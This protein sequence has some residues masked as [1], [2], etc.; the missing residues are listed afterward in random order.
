M[1][2]STFTNVYIHICIF[3]YPCMYSFSVPSHAHVLQCVLQCLL[4]SAF[5][6]THIYM[7]VYVN[8]SLNHALG[9]GTCIQRSLSRTSMYMSHAHLCRCL[10]HIYMLPSH[11]HLHATHAALSRT[12]TCFP[13]THIYM[14][15]SHA[16][17]H[18]T[19][20]ALLRT[21]HKSATWRNICSNHLDRI[22]YSFGCNC[23]G[24]SR[25]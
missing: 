22:F 17:P 7:H 1:C 8:M 3:V 25:R 24:N 19:Q 5:P 13:L 9:V 10:T 2:L 15:P 11:A 6:L 23:Q 20:A 4:R 21:S 18:A 12:S 16:H 14:L